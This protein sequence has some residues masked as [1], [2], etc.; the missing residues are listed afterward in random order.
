MRVLAIVGDGPDTEKELEEFEALGVAHDLMV[1]NRGAGRVG[2]RKPAWM[3][4]MHPEHFFT[5]KET[6]PYR[7]VAPAR[8]ADVV[9]NDPEATR[10]GGSALYGVLFALQMLDYERVVLCGCPLTGTHEGLFRWEDCWGKASRA[11]RR[12]VR[13]MSGNTQAL[14][15]TPTKDW[16]EGK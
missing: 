9:W 15:G 2:Q 10:C 7:V 1:L 6:R 5:D 16:L 14:L 8:P 11:F 13:S 12:R 4:T 3:A